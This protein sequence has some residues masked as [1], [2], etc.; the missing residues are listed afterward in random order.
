[1]SIQRRFAFLLA[2]LLFGF[3]VALIVVGRL[4]RAEKI[5]MV[6]ADRESRTQLLHH[7]SELT[8]RALPQFA[9]DAAQSEEFAAALDA[10]A[11]DSERRKIE[12]AL[13]TARIDALW[14]VR[15]D[16]SVR[17]QMT[18][19]ATLAAPPL[20]LPANEFASVVNETPSP[21]FFAEQG[22]ELWEVCIRRLRSTQPPEWLVVGRRWDDIQLR[23]LASLT[24][25]AVSLA[26]PSQ[27]AQPAENNRLVLS[28]PLADWRGRPLRLLRME[29]E[30]P[31]IEQALE[32]EAKRTQV[33]FVFGLSL[34]VA[35]GLALHRWV[36]RPLRKIGQSL[37]TDDPSPASELSNDPSELGHAAKLV[38]GSFDQRAAL[39]HEIAER[40]RMHEALERSEASLRRNMEE[41]SR[42]GRDLHD[43]VIQSLYAAGMGLAG[44]RALLRPE[45]AEAATRL[46]QTRGVL[47][48]TIHDVRNF[49]IGL[50]PEALK[51]QTFS[52]A[53]GALLDVMR[54]MRPFKSALDIDE[55]LAG[56]LTLAQRVHA[57]QIT[58]EAVSNALRHGEASEVQVGLRPHGEFAEFEVMDNGSGFETDFAS[59]Q[60][61]GLRNF[62]QRARE[63]GAE[64]TVD[65]RP[66]RGT[67]VKLVFSIL[68]HE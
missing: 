23:A 62:A 65:S 1:M 47:N 58:R 68:S 45:Q 13:A 17:L 31:E 24:E 28:R 16:G 63:L 15:D 64:L 38:V 21:R 9:A 61:K 32:T 29:Y 66:G 11:I 51:L 25:S 49:I 19:S 59:S 37:A 54:A 30:V 34:M 12:Q 7:W 39:R 53:I 57:L 14:V 22:E 42:L 26:S 20:P 44:I 41:R 36:L 10:M 46:E 33:F 18:S 52:Q 50:E 6:A 55:K 27:N 8:S 2:L 4:E 5:E 43:G 48:E 60:G 56:R 40:T 67:R 35:I 3:L